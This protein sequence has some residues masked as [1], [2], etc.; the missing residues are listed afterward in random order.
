MATAHWWPARTLGRLKARDS[1][2]ALRA[3]VQTGADAYVRVEALR[4]LVAIK[5]AG[6]LRP[7]LDELC[8]DAPFMVRELARE[9]LEA[10]DAAADRPED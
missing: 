10:S 7:W 9:V 8:R 2:P 1:V 5:G 4:S 6:C 3:T